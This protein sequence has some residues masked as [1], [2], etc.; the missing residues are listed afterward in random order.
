MTSRGTRLSKEFPVGKQKRVGGRNSTKPGKK[1]VN[2]VRGTAKKTI[3]WLFSQ[4]SGTRGLQVSHNENSNGIFDIS[5]D[6]LSEDNGEVAPEG[7]KNDL[8][9]SDPIAEFSPHPEVSNLGESRAQKSPIA[10]GS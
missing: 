5:D 6:S 8:P 4:A 3:P 10:K 7:L 1:P 2:R 9:L